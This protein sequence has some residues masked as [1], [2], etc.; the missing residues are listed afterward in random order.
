[1]T[2]T[3]SRQAAPPAAAA[4]RRRWS[5]LLFGLGIG[6]VLVLEQLYLVEAAPMSLTLLQR[7][8]RHL[9]VHPRTIVRYCRRLE[10]EG[11]LT[12]VSSIDLFVN[13]VVALENDVRHL[14]RLWR[15]REEQARLRA[16]FGRSQDA[17]GA[18]PHTDA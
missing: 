13:P 14:V 10:R 17:A 7:R 3:A 5:D 15:I 11:L 4:S 16:P 18:S 1:M 6:E 2:P 8:L 9:N 12:T